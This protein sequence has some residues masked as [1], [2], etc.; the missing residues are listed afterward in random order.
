MG[1]YLG[2]GQYSMEFV[3]H[4]NEKALR[5]K[6]RGSDF[7]NGSKTGERPSTILRN[8]RGIVQHYFIC[9]S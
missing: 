7:D 1:V 8:H 3:A 5:A 6:S 2:E 9:F 4:G